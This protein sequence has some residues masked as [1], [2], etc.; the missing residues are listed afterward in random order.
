MRW[1]TFTVLMVP[2]LRGK[3]YS[4]FTGDETGSMG[5][6]DYHWPSSDQADAPA[7]ARMCLADTLDHG[8][9]LSMVP[10]HWLKG[11]YH[12]ALILREG[13]ANLR[14]GQAMVAAV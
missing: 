14:D 4:H 9:G 8:Q 2:S 3:Y 13:P 10:A 12:Y 5:W 1:F 7:A 11:K 6:I